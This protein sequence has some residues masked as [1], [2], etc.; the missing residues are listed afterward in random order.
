[1]NARGVALGIT[2]AMSSVLCCTGVGVLAVVEAVGGEDEPVLASC[3]TGGSAGAKVAGLTADQ[4]AN[5]AVIVRVGQQ[6][7]IPPRG[8]VIAVA[9][10]LQE[11]RLNNLANTAVPASM[12]LPH[13][14]AGHDHDSVGLFQQ[15]PN[16]PDG[17]GSWGAVKELM[18][19]ATS[20]RKFFG[21]L[22]KV[23]GWQNLS[24]TDAAQ[25]VQR[26]A[27]PNAY[28]KHEA[29]ASA[30]VDQ[31]SGGLANAGTGQDG[32]ATAGEV[33][34]SGWTAP[35]A[36]AKVGSG[37]GPRAGRMHYGVDLMVPRNTAVRAVADGTVIKAVCDAGI[38]C[39]RDGS[40]ST[41]GCGWFVDLRHADGIIT[42]YCH[43][44]IRPMVA[45]G[46]RVVAG[47]Q[48]GLSGT[49]GHSSGPHLHFE[50]HLNGDEHAATGATDPV[51][52]MK[53]KGVKLGG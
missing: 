38:N 32:C 30:I 21:A 27:Y 13:Q 52:F 25:R 6:M 10:A 24:L 2:I 31:V 7:A 50:V 51:A 22:L 53:S 20:A 35:V 43:M 36:G 1:M 33:T 48:I 11:S 26:S 16:P 15:R 47:Q 4:S 44:V 49:S 14:G 34:A 5:A 23:D 37:F 8:W 41:P 40:P 17:A 19:P 12:S 18:D 28:A 42:R 46:D 9:T 45:A 29:R 3:D 39:D